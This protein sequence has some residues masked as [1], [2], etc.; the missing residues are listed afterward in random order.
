MSVPLKSKGSQQNRGRPTHV[1][2]FDL[3]AGLH[4]LRDVSDT[5]QQRIWAAPL[6]HN[7]LF[8]AVLVVALWGATFIYF[9]P[10]ESLEQPGSLWS[11]VFRW[12]GMTIFVV[13]AG[14]SG[15]RAI[16]RGRLV[17]NRDERTLSFYYLLVWP[18]VGRRQI[19]LDEIATLDVRA[20]TVAGGDDDPS[21]TYRIV[22]AELRDR[23]LA[24]IAFDSTTGIADAIRDA[25]GV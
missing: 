24:S 10:E 12:M 25:I 8:L 13:V 19:S 23:R 1:R 17:L 15:L 9:F 20:L 4:G 2:D 14:L 16:H 6:W 21:W 5:P 11:D 3:N 18:R 7:F 22:V